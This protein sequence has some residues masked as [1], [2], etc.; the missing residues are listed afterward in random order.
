MHSGFRIRKWYKI[1]VSLILY[2]FLVL[3]LQN[4]GP[5]LYTQIT[6]DTAINLFYFLI[7]MLIIETLNNGGTI[8]ADITS[9]LYIDAINSEAAAH[10]G[11]VIDGIPDFENKDLV[12]LIKRKVKILVH[13]K[14]SDNDIRNARTNLALEP[15]SGKSFCFLGKLPDAQQEI[16]KILKSRNELL[17]PRGRE[18]RF[19]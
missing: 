19:D 6:S 17:P 11:V 18:L 3:I 15:K 1:R 2:D 14:L 4:K 8:G 13:L 5:P 12:D 7:I 16:S 10:Y 9:K